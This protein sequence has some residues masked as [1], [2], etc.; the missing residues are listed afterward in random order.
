MQSYLFVGGP[1][2][3]KWRTLNTCRQNACCPIISSRGLPASDLFSVYKRVEFDVAPRP[4]PMYAE[5]S[6]SRAQ[7]L[8]K[9]ILECV[10]KKEECRS[11]LRLVEPLRLFLGGPL[12][13][14]V[15]PMCQWPMPSF[16]Y[17]VTTQNAT[18][19]T[20]GLFY[21][22]GS[23]TVCDPGEPWNVEFVRYERRAFDIDGE[24]INLY[25]HAGMLHGNVLVRLIL[26]YPV[27][28]EEKPET[29]V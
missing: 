4:V 19:V 15:E 21:P 16:I 1:M 13:G 22:D 2:D 6:M 26:E 7:V 12:H 14:N 24:S 29:A 17:A 5:A 27:A 23:S 25:A 8:R 9:L 3:G 28:G 11:F 10:R 18:Q 20:R